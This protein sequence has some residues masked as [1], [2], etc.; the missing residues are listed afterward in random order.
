MRACDHENV[1][2]LFEVYEA[3]KH[4]HLVL[5]VLEGGELLNR[6]RNKGSYTEA[7]AIKL[8]RNILK[9]MAYLHSKGIVHRDLKPD[10]LLLASSDDDYSVK[11]ADFGLATF[12]EPGAKLSLPCGSPGYV[13][14]ELLQD[15]S[16]GYDTKADIY[17]VG[18]I[19][20]ILLIGRPAFQGA[21]YKQILKKNTQGDPPYPKRFWSKISEN[22]QEL[23]KMMIENDQDK[24]LSAEEALRHD[25]FKDEESAQAE[26]LEEAVEGL[27]EFQENEIDNSNNKTDVSNP[28]LTVTPVMAGRH[29]KDTCE[30]PWNPSGLTPK[31][32]DAT[33]M[34]IHGFSENRPK[35]VVDIPGL[36]AIA[37]RTPQVVKE[38][39]KKP[40]PIKNDPLAA[41]FNKFEEME[42]KRKNRQQ[43]GTMNFGKGIVGVGRKVS[44]DEEAKIHPATNLPV[45]PNKINKS[46]NESNPNNVPVLNKILESN[47]HNVS[48]EKGMVDF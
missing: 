21:D 43:R 32:A 15:P 40:E 5:E 42:N 4:V 20:Y 28:L 19:L 48:Q 26:V 36:G 16:P 9:A 37:A 13:A 23:V 44:N 38:E 33:P 2:K 31:I 14:F 29:L 30:S 7:D 41:N 24:R 27:K 34:L 35:R 8:M 45:M 1:I 17:S 11:I 47:N 39:L 10:N 22:G 46:P 25:W 18:V 12:V 6:I 3:D